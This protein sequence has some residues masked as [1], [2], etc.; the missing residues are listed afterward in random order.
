MSE[1]RAERI[2]RFLP[3]LGVGLAAV[4]ALVAA[5][6]YIQRGAHPE[7]QGRIQKVRSLAL[8]DS[9]TVVVAD[10]RCTNV[11]D[12]PFVVRR[13]DLLV[14]TADG[15]LLEG[16]LVSEIDA[17]RLFEYYPLLGPKYNPT[18]LPRTRIGPHQSLDRMVAARFE[19]AEED[20]ARRRRLAIRI[21]DV[22]GAVSELREA[23]R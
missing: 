6:F 5:V 12:Y 20:L 19:L 14:E 23:G 11:A 22:D 18:L 16:S 13:V 15:R 2:R 3:F 17:S 8:P 4:A 21:E 1:T 9:S 7:L 10:F